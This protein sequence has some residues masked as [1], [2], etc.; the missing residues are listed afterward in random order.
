M[1]VLLTRLSALGDI[2]HTWPL[3]EALAR[4]GS[5]VELG[6]VVEEGFLPL[7]A[8][9]PAVSRTIPIAT[10]RWR[11]RPLAATTR[12]EIFSTLRSVREFAPE[13][14]LD[15]QGLVK[16]AVWGLLAGA[17]ARVGLVRSCRRELLAGAFYTCTVTPPSEAKHVVD[18]NLSLL[19]AVGRT[20]QFGKVPDAGFMLCGAPGGTLGPPE[21]AVALLPGTGGRGKAWRPENYAAL[22]RRI[23][24]KGTPVVVMWGPGER[25]LAEGI[26]AAA[27]DGTTLAP[28]TSIRELAVLMSKCAG[29]VGG[30]T[31]PIHLSAA[32]GVPTV[33]VFVATDPERNGPRGARVRVVSAAAGATQ[34]GSAHS[35]SNGEVDVAEVFTVLGGILGGKRLGAR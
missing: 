20:A 28:P 4:D 5:P 17:P 29:V 8:G 14:A 32:L 25:D 16:S 26:A 23:T 2:I 10:R 24:A 13:L 27:G 3:A 18:I 31:G 22:A 21:G 15:P 34:R 33:A 6:W 7:V 12:R 35:R 1:R 30:D 19:A 9:H 11:R